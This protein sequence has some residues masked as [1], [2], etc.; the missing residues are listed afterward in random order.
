MACALGNITLLGNGVEE[1]INSI[2]VLKDN[3]CSANYLVLADILS[4][5]NQFSCSF[6]L[7]LLVFQV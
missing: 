5:Q 3:H 7:L 4:V 2:Q 1:S 6:A